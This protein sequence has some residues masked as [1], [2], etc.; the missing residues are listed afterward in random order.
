MLQLFLHNPFS[1]PIEMQPTA[2]IT[3]NNIIH[4]STD[5]FIKTA[6]QSMYSWSPRIKHCYHQ[7][8]KILKFFKIYSPNNCEF[9]CSANRSLNMCGCVAFY[10]PSK[11]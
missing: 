3:G 1:M 4:I 9:E 5:L 7:H 2:Y 6:T 11:K 10:H 8:D